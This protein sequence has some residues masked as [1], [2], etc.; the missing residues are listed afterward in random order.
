MKRCPKCN[1][2]F[3]D[4]NQ[5]FCTVDGGLLI[6]A[7]P[8]PSAAFDPNQTIRATS[9]ELGTQTPPSERPTSRELPDLNAT[10]AA[11]AP[12]E[13]FPRNTSRTGMPTTSDLPAAPPPPTPAP[14]PVASEPSVSAPLPATAAPKKKSKLGLILGILAVLLVLG[15]GGAAAGFF[16]ILKPM[17]DRKAVERVETPPVTVTATEPSPAPNNNTAVAEKSPEQ[18][19]FVP[20]EGTKK[21]ENTKANL[22]GKLAEHYIDFSFYYPQGWQLDPKPGTSNFTRVERR[23]P[24]DFIQENLAVGWYDSKG[25][26]EADQES[27]SQLVQKLSD[28]FSKG[29]PEFKKVSEGSTK[30]NSMDAYEFRFTGLSKGTEKGDINIWGRVIFLP[31][32]IAG[33]T[34][35]ATLV[36]L[37][38]SLAPELS[39]VE[40]VGEK[41]EMPVIL[42]S[43]RFAKK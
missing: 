43:F 21:F 10:I 18:P 26:F 31:R 4:E 39:S 20:P 2:S 1:R 5:K 15:I 38:T 36:M 41:G 3:P 40:D 19:E 17:L 8:T 27:F 34:T 37:S 23:L 29:I 28:S 9:S 30:V 12:T 25:T 32:G 24:P 35:G 33:E 42:E 7:Q 22:D 13:M 14:Q 6:A 11:S 16:L